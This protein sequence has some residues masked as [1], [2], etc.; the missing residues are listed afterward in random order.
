MILTS[1]LMGLKGGAGASSYTAAKFGVTG[2]AKSLA[3]E[4]APYRIRVNSIHPTN[5]RT[6]MLDSEMIRKTF[7][8][9]LEN[10]TLDDT[11]DAYSS[12]NMWP[13]P[14]WRRPTCPSRCCIW[15]RISR[16]RSP[17]SPSRSTS[18]RPPSEFV[19]RQRKKL[20]T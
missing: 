7:R 3:A 16:G 8:P 20:S 11:I 5:V 14:G 13:L 4:L 1:S 18:G 12:L 2:L 15:R 9:D 6:P 19:N 17:V 10:P